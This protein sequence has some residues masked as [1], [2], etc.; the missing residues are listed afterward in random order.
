MFYELKASICFLLEEAQSKD[1]IINLLLV[2]TSQE[3]GLLYD[4]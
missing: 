1:Q 3:I 4:G 2:E